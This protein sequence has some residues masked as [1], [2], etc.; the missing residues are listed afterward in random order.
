MT[1]TRFPTRPFVLAALL[2]LAACNSTQ[3]PGPAARAP[4]GGGE[5]VCA[6]SQL[7]GFIGQPANAVDLSGNDPMRILPPGSVVTM[8]YNPARLNV[9]LDEAGLITRFYCG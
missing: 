1:Q 4:G 3:S 6:A 7:S 8:D 9:E 2:A 5:G